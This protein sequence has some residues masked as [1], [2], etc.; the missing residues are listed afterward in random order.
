[1]FDKVPTEIRDSVMRY[2]SRET[3]E[4]LSIY[5][6]LI[7]QWNRRTGL[8][9]IKTL[10]D[11]WQR[12][13]LDSLQLIPLL[14][15]HTLSSDVDTSLSIIDIGTGAGFPGM[16]L[17]IVG[18]PNITLC[19]SNVRKCVFLEEVARL[20]KTS[21][22]I[23]NNRIEH[24]DRKHDL[25]LSRACA[26]L[27]LLLEYMHF[28]SRETKS[29]ALFHKGKNVNQEICN[30]QKKWSFSYHKYQSIV[31]SE[32]YILEITELKPK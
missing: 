22:K 5:I 30:A 21:V 23:T 17:A 26:E 20:T 18:I 6:D 10:D 4:R 11:V 15:P 7:Q 28:V 3:I 29:R 12:H 16:V 8:I 2:V 14:T 27:N 9:Q 1:M 25:I 31:N 32:G 24:L 19:E 13:I